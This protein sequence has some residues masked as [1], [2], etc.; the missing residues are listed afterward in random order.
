MGSGAN[1]TARYL[2]GAAG[3]ARVVALAARPGAGGL[4][5]GW[6]TAAAVSAVLC[7]VGALTAFAM[8]ALTLR[9]AAERRR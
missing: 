8:G 3:V 2:G 1:N 9:A 4:A 5:H 7:A 6:N